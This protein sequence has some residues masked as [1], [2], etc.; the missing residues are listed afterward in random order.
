MGEAGPPAS[1]PARAAGSGGR[2]ALAGALGGA[3]AGVLAGGLGGA[4]GRCIQDMGSPE[5]DTI[6]PNALVGAAVW[7]V[8]AAA[9]GALAGLIVGEQRGRRAALVWPCAA[10]F[11]S[12]LVASVETAQVGPWGGAR[13]FALSLVLLLALFA[14]WRWVRRG[15]W[16]ARWLLLGW[17]ALCLVGEAYSRLRPKSFTPVSW[18]PD[19]PV[20][21]L[22]YSPLP[23]RLGAVAVHYH[24]LTYDPA[25]GCWHRWDLWQYPDQGGTAHWGH[26]HRDLLDPGSGVGGDPPRIEREW[27]GD[28]ARALL[29]ALARSPEYPYRDKYLAWPGPNSNTYPA[30]VLREAGVSADLD[31]RG[32]GRDYHGRVGA[33]RTTTRTGVGAGCATLGVTVGLEDGVELH[34]LCFTFGLD[35][36]PPA[37]KT[38]LGRVGFAE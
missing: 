29:S 28:E 32:I 21:Q 5:P 2:H 27:R 26:V 38:P 19:E 30:W 8:A 10:A 17:L 31:P 37:I 23:T 33:G 6:L 16:K 36:W 35:A 7:G 25:E 14:A 13:A 34:F 11:W 15:L 9:A 20:V 24:F 12:V 3:L 18:R 4:F 22:G 1:Q